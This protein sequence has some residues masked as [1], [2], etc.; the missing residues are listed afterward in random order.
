MLGV[1]QRLLGA[2]S[3]QPLEQVRA[4]AREELARVSSWLSDAECEGVIVDV[5]SDAASMLSS[6]FHPPLEVLPSIPRCSLCAIVLAK[7]VVNE[8][9][10]RRIHQFRAQGVRF[11]QL[12]CTTTARS[13]RCDGSA[14]HGSTSARGAL[15]RRPIDLAALI[16]TV[17]RQ[18]KPSARLALR[19][20]EMDASDASLVLSQLMM[21]QAICRAH[22]VMLLD[23]W[24]G[25]DANTSARDVSSGWVRW[26][27]DAVL[28]SLSVRGR[29][30][31]CATERVITYGDERVVTHAAVRAVPRQVVTRQ[32]AAGQVVARQSVAA[33]GV[34]WKSV[35]GQA[36][37]RAAPRQVGRSAV[38]WTTVTRATAARTEAVP[39]PLRC[40]P[41]S[42]LESAVKGTVKS[43]EA[44][45]L[46][47]AALYSEAEDE[48]ESI[49]EMIARSPCRHAD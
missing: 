14:S 8:H 49:R 28:A 43:A 4:T 32:G 34:A 24:A 44:G 1:V 45:E 38:A 7:H 12:P 26:T 10:Q 20:G 22:E 48:R 46:A 5:G 21:E 36:V 9:S 29:G 42:T 13:I 19:L 40:D 2:P 30:V 25:E 47:L 17:A 6:V 33:Q 18:L 41:A 16:H 11:L 37:A 31:S 27:R 3:E 23:R 39:T 15:A 35:T